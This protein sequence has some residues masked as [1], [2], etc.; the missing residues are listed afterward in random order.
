MGA[1]GLVQTCAAELFITLALTSRQRAN[2]YFALTGTLQE[3]E[4]K[5]KFGKDCKGFGN[6]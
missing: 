5:E 4:R 6:C 2:L 1:G 3:R